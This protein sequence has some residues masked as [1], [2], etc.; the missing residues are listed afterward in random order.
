M[1]ITAMAGGYA[2]ASVARQLPAIW[3]KRL[4]IAVGASLT[5]IYFFKTYV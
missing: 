3:L 2:G 4:V 5:V 1:L